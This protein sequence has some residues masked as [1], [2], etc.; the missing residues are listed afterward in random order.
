VENQQLDTSDKTPEEF[1][2]EMSQTRDALSEKVAALEDQVVGTVQTAADTLTG[3]V[4]SVK[5]FITTAPG[6]VGDSVRQAATA[7]SETVKKTFDISGHVRRHP[8]TSVG[9]SALLGC[10]TG[11]LISRSRHPAS[12]RTEPAPAYA[13]PTAAP[14]PTSAPGVFDDL[15]S[16]LGRKIREFAETAID[17]AS[18][19]VNRNVR[20]N[21]PK[22]VDAA[23]N[24]LAP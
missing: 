23:A 12:P 8:W 3:T 15:V 7:V 9:V 13:P 5:S 17:S 4:E 16:M 11:W 24:R 18:E 14:P 20:D 21:V 1:Q 2:H 19:A 10:V 6:V 22:L